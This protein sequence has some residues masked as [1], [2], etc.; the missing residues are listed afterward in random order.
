MYNASRK[1]ILSHE[2]QPDFD[3]AVSSCNAIDSIEYHS[4]GAMP[5]YMIGKGSEQNKAQD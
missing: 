2:T 3:S 5:L 4:D 1:A